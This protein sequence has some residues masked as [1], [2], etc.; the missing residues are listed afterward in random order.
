MDQ[1]AYTHGGDTSCYGSGNCRCGSAKLPV[2]CDCHG[3][4]T[5]D[6]LPPLPCSPLN[7]YIKAHSTWPNPHR[8]LHCPIPLWSHDWVAGVVLP[9]VATQSGDMH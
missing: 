9:T 6:C 2:A 7:K 3:M 1:Q 4:L 8:L 5:L